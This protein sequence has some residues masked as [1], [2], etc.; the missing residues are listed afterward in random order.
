MIENDNAGMVTN[1]TTGME[2]RMEQGIECDIYVV[3]GV[4]GCS[5]ISLLKYIQGIVGQKILAVD[6]VDNK[7]GIEYSVLLA[8]SGD[9]FELF[10]PVFD[11]MVKSFQLSPNVF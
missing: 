2:S 1:D 4:Q 7:T 3:N 10:K 6:A 5:F 11:H 9:V 8:A